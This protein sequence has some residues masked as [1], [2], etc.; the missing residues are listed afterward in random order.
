M[1][2]KLN[3]KDATIVHD[4]VT[5]LVRDNFIYPSHRSTAGGALS[6]VE[7]SDREFAAHYPA[8]DLLEAVNIA[9]AMIRAY[10]NNRVR[11]KR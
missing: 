9:K 3:D 1:R 4:G 2:I 5:Y 10:D 7:S 6:G 11:G 8:H